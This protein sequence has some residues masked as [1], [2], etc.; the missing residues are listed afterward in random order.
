MTWDEWQEIVDLT[1]A[2]HKP[3]L[4]RAERDRENNPL[5]RLLAK[6]ANPTDPV[7]PA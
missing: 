7:A 4:E 2:H 5:A 1:V 3:R 6:H